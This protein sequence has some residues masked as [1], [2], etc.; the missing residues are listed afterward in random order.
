LLVLGCVAG[1]S[2]E[3]GPLKLQWGL[4]LN[5]LN[6]KFGACSLLISLAWFLDESMGT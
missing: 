2:I 1:S 6:A 5:M 3:D 4:M